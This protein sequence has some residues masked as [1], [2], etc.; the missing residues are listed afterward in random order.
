MRFLPRQIYLGSGISNVYML[1]PNRWLLT[2]VVIK[3]RLPISGVIIT[4]EEGYDETYISSK[5]DSD[6]VCL[7]TVNWGYDIMH[8]YGVCYS[9]LSISND[10][11]FELNTTIQKDKDVYN[12]DFFHI[13]SIPPYNAA[14]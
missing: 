9:T 5:I 14:C 10:P 11:V 7:Y 2:Q 3:D 6:K 13:I 4:N 8:M 12:I 1:D